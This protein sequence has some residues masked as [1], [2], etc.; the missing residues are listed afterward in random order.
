M[1]KLHITYVTTG[2]NIGGAEMM[3]YRLIAST[4]RSSFDVSVISLIDKG[5]IGAQIASLGVPV[6]ALGLH[7]LLALPKAVL[8]LRQKLA[9]LQ[10]DLIQGW[11]YHGNLFGIL[12]AGLTGNFPV[13]WGIRQS[14]YD[15]H[16]EKGTTAAIIRLSALMSSLPR[17]IIYN[18][19]ISAEHH[20]AIGY[21]KDK[22]L[23][24][25]NGFDC[26]TFHPSSTARNKLL[27]ELAEDADIL[28]IG[29][30]GRYHKAKDHGNFIQAA[31]LIIAT[32]PEVRFVLVG[33]GVNWENQALR[34][35]IESTG[36]AR[37]FHL[38]GE[39]RDVPDI[40]AGLDI[41][42]SSSCT[43]AFPN[44]VGE[45]MACGV[46]CIVTDVGESARIVEDTG[47]VV[48][49]RNPVALALAMQQVI[50]ISTTERK[51]LGMR[52]R[53]RIE[54]CYSLDSVAEQYQLLHHTIM[55]S[56]T[57]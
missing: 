2:L 43:E 23:I 27:R 3:L 42:V 8:R 25:P 14:L 47:I 40:M 30:I 39:R 20:E 57:A 24:I 12:A 28:L 15:L 19:R 32:H 37:A 44:V 36:N 21:A 45:A 10:P 33:S 16:S 50:R 4:D 26:T 52:A 41:V 18:S 9:D 34:T 53:Q 11:M 38:L 31:T 48:P 13:V 55:D 22:R 29:L 54:N 1:R 49:P 6:F 17:Q 7:S 46:P 5:S 35:A 51:L 56:R